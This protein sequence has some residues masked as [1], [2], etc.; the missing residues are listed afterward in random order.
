[1]SFGIAKTPFKWVFAQVGLD[2]LPPH[3]HIVCDHLRYRGL[4]FTG[5]R[6]N[7]F[8]FGSQIGVQRQVVRLK[9]IHSHMA[10]CFV[11]EVERA[12]TY[13]SIGWATYRATGVASKC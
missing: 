4:C 13:M 12:V 9:G 2:G 11:G 7:A 10:M 8:V 3:N 1:M 5:Q 6:W